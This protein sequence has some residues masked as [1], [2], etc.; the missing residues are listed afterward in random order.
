MLGII[1]LP[2]SLFIVECCILCSIVIVTQEHQ[3]L[4]GQ[5]QVYHFIIV[6]FEERKTSVPLCH[7]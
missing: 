5:F 6:Y 2:S 7:S 3:M 1:S 4:P